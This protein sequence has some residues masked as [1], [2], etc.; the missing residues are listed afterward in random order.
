MD[1]KEKEEM[2]KLLGFSQNIVEVTYR[3]FVQNEPLKVVLHDILS[4]GSHY[5]HQRLEEIL[6][7]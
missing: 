3:I 2:A 6:G 1:D 7:S 4:Q 5:N